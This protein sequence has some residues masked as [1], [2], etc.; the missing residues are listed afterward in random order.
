MSMNDYFDDLHAEALH[1]AD[2]DLQHIAETE[3][4]SAEQYDRITK[5]AMQKAG[6]AAQ[7][8]IRRKKRGKIFTL[9]IAA[10]A[11]VV[12][13]GAGAS[14]WMLYNRQQAKQYF[15]EI[16]TAKLEE[17][18]LTEAQSST[19]GRIR[20]DI[21]A[22]LNDGKQM[23]A[24]LT[25]TPEDPAQKINWNLEARSFY[26]VGCEP[27]TFTAILPESESRQ[28]MRDGSLRV[29][30]GF[31]VHDPAAQEP[32][33]F[34]YEKSP[35]DLPTEEEIRECKASG[36]NVQ[37][38]Y[39]DPAL[40]GES[41]PYYDELADGLE[42]TLTV[43]ANVPIICMKNSSGESLYLSGFE[44]YWDKPV[45]P[46]ESPSELT[47]T[48]AD[49]T[50]T[51]LHLPSFS[52]NAWHDE[53]GKGGFS[54]AKIYAEIPEAKF[55]MGDPATYNGFIDV[56]QIVSLDWNGTQYTPQAVE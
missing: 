4:L 18:G 23:I 48:N 3:Q 44:A 37:D 35:T 40:V 50:Q 17:L 41:D 22:V 52:T 43:Q 2:A 53:N 21:T 7:K 15:G 24:L 31:K 19:N 32:V 1:G 10:A 13:L 26:E 45:L 25:F 8:P 28:E 27:G 47:V 36:G 49:G 38:L 30:A 12:V 55:K 51:V 42:F 20:L 33:T 16:G 56:S 46:L 54:S 9:L 5:A 11:A 14:G 29:T 34:R 39:S 6:I